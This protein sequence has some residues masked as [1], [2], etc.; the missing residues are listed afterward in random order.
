MPD[1]YNNPNSRNVFDPAR[2]VF[3][4]STEEG[5]YFRRITEE[6][7]AASPDKEGRAVIVYFRSE[8]DI[9]RYK[10]SR[11]YQECLVGNDD[12][13]VQMILPSGD[14]DIDGQVR[15]ATRPH[16]ITLLTR[17]HTR[18]LDFKVTDAGV[19]N[20]GMHVVMTYLPEDK[21]EEVQAMGRTARQEQKGSFVMVLLEPVL[22][23]NVPNLDPTK[24]HEANAY[25]HIDSLRIKHYEYV[26][27]GRMT[28]VQNGPSSDAHK[29]TMKY[30]KILWRHLRSSKKQEK[31]E[32]RTHALK[33]LF[34][35]DEGCDGSKEQAI[36]LGMARREVR[37]AF[38]MDATGSMTTIWR[39]GAKEAVRKMCHRINEI[40]EGLGDVV[41]KFVAFYDYDL[42]SDEQPVAT[43][44]TWDRDPNQLV[45]FMDAVRVHGG[46]CDDETDKCE[47]A[48]EMGLAAVS[49]EPELDLVVLLGDAP[50][51]AHLKGHAFKVN[52]ELTHTMETDFREQCGILKANKVPM[53]CYAY[54][55]FSEVGNYVAL[56]SFKEMAELTGGEAGTIASMADSETITN[57]VSARVLDIIGGTALV[58]KYNA[59]YNKTQWRG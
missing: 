8:D 33:F 18:G 41:F 1:I 11:S 10:R 46:K 45:A 32:L 52:A 22:V 21:T 34:K 55:F 6:A 44:S 42:L 59:K 39:K 13:D 56:P 29:A 31:K 26:C 4:E 30:C 7:L 49:R 35:C 37:V 57:A 9:H 20:K 19:K 58:E 43:S 25:E 53:M 12:V 48:V 28:A 14:C 24:L 27:S 17:D 50:P 23:A 54:P 3:V 16:Q 51:H 36:A 38:V 47:E 2:N 40:A 15:R 5:G